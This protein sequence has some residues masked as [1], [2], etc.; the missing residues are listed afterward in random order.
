LPPALTQYLTDHPDIQRV[1]LRL[2]ND[3]AGRLATKAIMT[4]LLK[5]YD[6]TDEPPPN[7]RKD[8]NDYLCDCSGLPRTKRKEAVR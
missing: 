4:V 5:E 3:L 2:D 6:V 8:Y 7:G 1:H